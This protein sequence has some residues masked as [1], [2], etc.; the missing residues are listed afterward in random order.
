MGSTTKVSNRPD[1]SSAGN[2]IQ[3]YKA[4]D[5][6]SSY[7]P[8][9]RVVVPKGDLRKMHTVKS[10]V[11]RDHI[12]SEFTVIQQKEKAKQ[13]IED[14]KNDVRIAMQKLGLL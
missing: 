8:K 4:V 2:G 7:V 13:A 11:H 5:P 1:S 14:S 12:P 6:L 3:K 10:K 9:K